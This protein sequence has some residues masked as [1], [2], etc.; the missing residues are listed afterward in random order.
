VRVE[1][2]GAHVRV[3]RSL[4][5]GGVESLILSATTNVTGQGSA[6]ITG[7]N[8]GNYTV[9]DVRILASDLSRT[10]A[11]TYRANNEIDTA[12]DYN[13][14]ASYAF[15]AWGRTSSESKNG[16]TRTYSWAMANLLA[17]IDS[18]DPAE[19]DVSYTYTGDLKRV[20][21]S[22]NG[23]LANLYQ[24]DA[25]F[26]VLNEAA[27]G[28]PLKTYV[29][30]LAEVSGN[31]L[32]TSATYNYL[33]QDH[34]GSTRGTWNASAAQTAAWEFTPYGAPYAFAGPSSVTHL[35]TGHDL[36]RA[37]G[38]YYAPFRTLN[39]ALGRWAS[40]DPLGMIDGTNVYGYAMQNP[41]NLRD[42]L[43]LATQEQCMKQYEEDSSFCRHLPQNEKRACWEA[44]A[45]RLANCL[46]NRPITRP[47][48]KRVWDNV[49]E[50]LKRLRE[51]PDWLKNIPAMPDLTVPFFGNPE[52]CP[53]S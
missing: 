48:L 45:E 16:T 11:M 1:A 22:E 43:G 29:P 23:A 51:I 6:R 49:A 20:W 37:T 31:A 32:E 2:D 21:R 8:G 50:R 14:A 7:L 36:D 17:G 30:G 15:D 42:L 3:W 5:G 34:L 53:N 40:Q 4:A 25:G 47:L 9:D 12:T 52:D 46:A 18:S 35:Y 10:T 41:S 38:Q 26:N 24:W 44:A 19:T 13:G 33:T 28:Q 27:V 39:P